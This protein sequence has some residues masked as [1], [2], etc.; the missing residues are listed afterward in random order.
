MLALEEK[1]EIKLEIERRVDKH[2]VPLRQG[3]SASFTRITLF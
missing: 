1:D 2:V 3:K